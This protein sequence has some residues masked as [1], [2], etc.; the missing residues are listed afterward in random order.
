MF[1]L[2]DNCLRFDETCSLYQPA[3]VWI[4]R[5][6]REHTFP[7]ALKP[8]LVQL[9]TMMVNSLQDPSYIEYFSKLLVFKEIM[10]LARFGSRHCKPPALEFL[11]A[12]VSVATA[13]L[14]KHYAE[15]HNL[16]DVLVFALELDLE[17]EL[18]FK[19]LTALAHIL[20]ASSYYAQRAHYLGLANLL[21]KF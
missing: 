15:E 17:D 10:F 6:L 5:R 8:N 4:E 16:L 21:G 18:A 3:S 11:A 20:G 13:E 9:M 1:E 14:L 12:V 7:Q 2:L 19:I